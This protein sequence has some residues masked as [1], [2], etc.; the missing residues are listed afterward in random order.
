V[1]SLVAL[2]GERLLQPRDGLAVIAA[3]DQVGADIVVGITVGGI[4]LDGLLAL[5]DSFVDLALVVLGPAQEGVR[6]GGG[7][8]FDGSFVELR[9]QFEVPLHLELVGVLK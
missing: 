6:F 2:A 3:L 8:H 1:I 9:G 7:V 5:V 4:D